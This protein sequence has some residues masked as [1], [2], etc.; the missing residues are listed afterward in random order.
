M[1][2]VFLERLCFKNLEPGFIQ[3]FY[4]PL[5]TLE[6]VEMCFGVSRSARE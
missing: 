6:H 2:T 4:I 5:V 1:A 3:Y